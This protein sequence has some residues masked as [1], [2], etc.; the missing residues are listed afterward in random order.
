MH[1]NSS[2]K[3][4]VVTSWPCDTSPRSGRVV[5]KIGGRELGQEVI[6]QIEVEIEARQVAAGLRQHLVDVK[7]RKQ[8]AAFGLL[9]DAAAAETLREEVGLSD[10]VGREVGEALPALAVGQEH[11]HA[12]LH[13][14]AARHRQAGLGRS[15]RS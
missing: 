11:A 4:S 8:H 1:L 3:L 7:L 6:G 9:A 13:G 14:L 12:G 10:L 15:R 2:K 5:R